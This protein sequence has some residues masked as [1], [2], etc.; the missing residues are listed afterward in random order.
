MEQPSFL[1]H[2]TSI[3]TL[4]MILSSKK[5]KFNS[6]NNVDDLNEGKSIDYKHIGGYFFI[7]CW[8]SFAEESLPFWN[9]YTPSMKGVRIKMPSNLFQCNLINTNTIKGFSDKEYFSIVSQEE[10]FKEKY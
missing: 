9:M 1:Y 4:A 7:S 3:E 5:I 6:L 2:Y 8:T 10:T